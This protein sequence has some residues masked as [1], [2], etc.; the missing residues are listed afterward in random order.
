MFVADVVNVLADES[1]IDGSTGK[2]ELERA[3][4]LSYNHGGYFGQ[5][6]YLGHFGFSVR[7]KK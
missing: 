1:L 3:G 6:E 7:K 4:L 2:F 5:G